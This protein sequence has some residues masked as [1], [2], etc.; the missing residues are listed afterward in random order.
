[1]TGDDDFNILDPKNV[2]KINVSPVQRPG[3]DRLIRTAVVGG[4]NKEGDRRVYLSVELLKNL[5]EIARSSP[6]RRCEVTRAGVRV[7]LY[8][9]PNGHQYEVW[10]LIG[11]N[12][13]PEQ[14]PQFIMDTVNST[15]ADA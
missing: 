5:L 10:T 15:K 3:T 6:M 2:L 11:A 1:M 7:D 4:P 8:L 9:T 12:P 14:V 13:R